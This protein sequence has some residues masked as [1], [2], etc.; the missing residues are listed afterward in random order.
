MMIGMMIG[1]MK[2]WRDK[3]LPNRDVTKFQ[4]PT[5]LMSL[6]GCCSC[7]KISQLSAAEQ[8]LS[9]ASCCKNLCLYFVQ[10]ILFVQ[11]T[12]TPFS[13]YEGFK[14]PATC[15]LNVEHGHRSSKSCQGA[16]HRPEL[17]RPPGYV[18]S[19]PAA[20][21]NGSRLSRIRSQTNSYLNDRTVDAIQKKV[22]TQS[23]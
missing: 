13:T 9:S 10:I 21:D 16:S 20:I 19:C 15:S 12:T 18:A 2:R 7:A 4:V 22:V 11:P 14:I 6:F 8:A 17:S 1:E 3:K 23:K 5:T